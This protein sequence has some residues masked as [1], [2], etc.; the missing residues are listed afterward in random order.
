MKSSRGVDLRLWGGRRQRILDS[1][2]TSCFY[3]DNDCLSQQGG[4]SKVFSAGIRNPRRGLFI[5]LAI[6]LAAWASIAWGVIEM[7][8]V[9][10]ET[11]GSGL[12]IGLARLPAI[13]GPLMAWNFW[14]AMKVFAAMRRGEKQIARW[15][16][17]AA[18]LAE[19][20]ASNKERNALGSEQV[21]DWSPPRASLSSGIEVIFA[22]DSVL[23]GDTYFALAITG[24]FRFTGVRMLIEGPPVIAFR[25]LATYANRFGMRTMVGELRIPVAL[26][27]G[28]EVTRVVKHFE[29]VAAREIVANPNFYRSRMRFGLIGAPIFFAVAAL[30]FVPGPSDMSDG[31]V[32]IP[33]LMVIIGMVA[34]GA[35]LILVLAAWLLDRAQARK[36]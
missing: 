24:P 20:A 35:M 10:R 30:G 36:R 16:V 27:A 11:S 33:S 12:K 3:P 18:E 13:I 22:A 1:L 8:A 29:Q 9:G 15:T 23:V 31:D 5:C 25:T 4:E 17:T 28:A 26:R 6:T 7:N 34:G 32:S 14:W 2:P 21:N 19:F